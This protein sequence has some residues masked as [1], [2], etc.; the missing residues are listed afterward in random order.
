MSAGIVTS[1]V[2][3]GSAAVIGLT[4]WGTYNGFQKR[5]EAVTQAERQIASCYQ[6]RADLI[7][8]MES[9]VER[10][11]KQEKDVVLG[12][13]QARAASTAPAKLPDNATPEQITEFIKAQGNTL[14]RLNAVME[15]VPNIATAANMALFQKD[16]KQTENQCNV[17]RNRY[18]DSVRAWNVSIRSF[19]S[20]M[21]ASNHGYTVKTQILFPNEEQNRNSPRVFQS[22]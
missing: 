3:L 17:L 19:P 2:V 16:L 21:V 15:A 11:M 22:K 8:N 12:N 20:N 5:E 14:S 7:A 6:K 13:A 10:I 1:A 9:A 4:Y 18:I